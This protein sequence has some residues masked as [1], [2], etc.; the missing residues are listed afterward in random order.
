MGTNGRSIHRE[1]NSLTQ[2]ENRTGGSY[3]ILQFTSIC[4][5]LW[6]VAFF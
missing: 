1:E 6:N 5:V 3:A 4:D 2:P